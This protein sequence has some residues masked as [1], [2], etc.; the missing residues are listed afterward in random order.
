M[1][2]VR[3]KCLDSTSLW[4]RSPR[5]GSPENCQAQVQSPKVQSPKV[6]TK[7]TWADT[8]ITPHPT[9]PTLTFKH[10][11]VLWLKVQMTH[12]AKKI[13]TGRQ[14]DQ[15]GGVVL[16]VQDGVYQ[17]TLTYLEGE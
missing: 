9:L 2:A 17:S 10:E 5:I 4:M 7:R 1:V 12:P 8:K 11:G 6:K 16:H 14:R 13:E 15:E 3:A